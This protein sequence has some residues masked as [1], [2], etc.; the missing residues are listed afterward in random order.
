MKIDC[1]AC[2]GAGL[3]APTRV[4][5]HG[6]VVRSFG[7]LLAV[8]SF[9]FGAF[10]VVVQAGVVGG[11]STPAGVVLYTLSS[12]PLLLAFLACF[13][14]FAL[15]CALIGTH[16]VYRCAACGFILPRA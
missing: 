11:M 6:V 16:K 13:A 5:R 12:L 2:H 4:P 7:G 14:A 1:Q 10:I 15:G 8:L 9:A 3:M